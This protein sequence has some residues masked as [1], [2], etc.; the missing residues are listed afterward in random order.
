MKGRRY[1]KT[2]PLVLMLVFSAK[3]FGQSA[4][5]TY[6]TSLGYVFIQVQH[7]K[8]GKAWKDPSGII[9][10]S[11]Q[12]HYPN[13][14]LTAGSDQY[15]TPYTTLIT[16]SQATRACAKIDGFLPTVETY[17]QLSNY[18]EKTPP[19]YYSAITYRGIQRVTDQQFTAQGIKDMLAIF[20]DMQE[21]SSGHLMWAD[22]W[23]ATA[24]KGFYSDYAGG[25][26]PAVGAVP[27]FDSWRRFSFLSVR[28]VSQKYHFNVPQ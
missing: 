22:F 17:A 19:E 13:L 5:V 20:P 6:T 18:F 21:E 25:F 4:P 11:N 24:I 9:W 12:G 2:I 23:S 26:M 3:V 10:S 16:D 1:M 28:C 7:K 14:T 8:F 15:D 27:W